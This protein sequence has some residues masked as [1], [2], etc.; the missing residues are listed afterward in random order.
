MIEPNCI[1]A[2]I[3]GISQIEY[4]D[5]FIQHLEDRMLLHRYTDESGI[6]E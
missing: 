4:A 5:A 6:L 3:P 2:R 1:L